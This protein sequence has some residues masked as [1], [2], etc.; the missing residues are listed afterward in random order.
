M[1][2]AGFFWV[3]VWHREKMAS[4]PPPVHFL[5]LLQVEVLLLLLSWPKVEV[6]GLGVVNQKD[7]S[8][9]WVCMCL[10]VGILC[11]LAAVTTEKQKWWINAMLVCSA[12]VNKHHTKHPLTSPPRTH[13]HAQP[14]HEHKFSFVNKIVWR[15]ISHHILQSTASCSVLFAPSLL[16]IENEADSCCYRCHSGFCLCWLVLLRCLPRYD[17][18]VCVYPVRQLADVHREILHLEELH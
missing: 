2:Q 17:V 10:C 1:A 13:A 12:R 18:C 9:G 16:F 14:R 15:Q 11:W 3:R 7:S 8:H 6:G 4:S 5:R